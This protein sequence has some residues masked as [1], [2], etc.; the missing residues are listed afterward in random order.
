MLQFRWD[1]QPEATRL[2]GGVL[3]G[4]LAGS[5]FTRNLAGRMR[6]DTGTRLFD[7]LDHLLVRADDAAA[8]GLPAKLDAHGFESQPIE[9]GVRY[10]HPGAILP[11]IVV[12]PELEPS[13]GVK[14]ESAADFLTTHQALRGDGGLHGA[15]VGGPGQR[16]RCA[17]IRPEGDTVYCTGVERH[18][19]PALEATQCPPDLIL[20]AQ[21]VYES[22]L[23]RRRDFGVGMDADRAGVAHVHALI[24]AGLNRLDRDWVCDLFFAAER[25]YWMR[26]NRAGREQYARQNTLGLGWA[27]HD[28]HTYRSSRAGFQGLIGVFEKLGFFCRERFFPGPGAGWG[29]Q[30]LEHPA[31]GIVI[32]A[33]VDIDPHE[34]RQDFAHMGLEDR[35]ELKTV[36]LWCALHGDSLLQAGMHHLEAQ[37]DFDRLR[38]QMKSELG[39]EMMDPFSHWDHLKQ[40]FTQGEVWAVRSER[41]EALRSA[42][43]ISDADAQKFLAEG[44]IGSHLENLERNDGYKGFNQTGIT[45]VIEETDPRKW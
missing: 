1:P 9:V 18:G 14:V 11:P 6:D 19:W 26:R 37:F 27:N 8:Q 5:A 29:A 10:S 24:D 43:R 23:S 44:T 42:G 36:G 22:F 45:S 38:A 33:D 7:W 40:Q 30:V 3:D 21:A 35:A 32:F 34:V 2:V 31:T 28:H 15:V 16:M 39:I 41:I 17:A 25:D 12:S 20:A 13:I 4:L